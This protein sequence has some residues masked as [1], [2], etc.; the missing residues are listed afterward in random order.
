V[1]GL[2]YALCEVRLEFVSDEYS[3]SKH[4]TP[5]MWTADRAE[6]EAWAAEK[7]DRV[8]I[9]LE[10]LPHNWRKAV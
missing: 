5:K 10:L 6:A 1:I 9:E 3:G 7:W 4:T 2:I 8:W